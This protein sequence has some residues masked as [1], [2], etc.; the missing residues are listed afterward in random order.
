MKTARPLV[1]HVGQGGHVGQV[2]FLA[3]SINAL[4]IQQ[5]AD[6]LRWAD[7]VAELSE[8][9]SP[10]WRVLQVSES[11]RRKTP[12]FCEAAVSAESVVFATSFFWAFSMNASRMLLPADDLRPAALG[13]CAR[14]AMP[15]G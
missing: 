6:D 12:A 5:V 3:I 2:N 10:F 4:L 14:R 11:G 7:L 15:G 1:G 9:N 8:V 13:A